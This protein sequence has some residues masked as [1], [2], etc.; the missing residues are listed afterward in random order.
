[1]QML[2]HQ[3]RR[4]HI[5]RDTRPARAGREQ[6][7]EQLIG[8][9]PATMLGQEREH[10]PGRHQMP[11]QR[12]RIQQLTINPA[13][14]LHTKILP[15]GLLPGQETSEAAVPLDEFVSE[16]MALLESEPDAKEILVER[17]KFL[18]YSKAR[19]DYDHVVEALNASDPHG[20]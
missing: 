2:Q 17:V 16:V 9:H 7:R 1:M 11:Y 12:R 20:K 8:E 13:R 3:H 4:D 14:P 15:A 19:G 18:R 6:V 10:A 5:G